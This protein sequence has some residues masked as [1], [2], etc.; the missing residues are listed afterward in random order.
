[1]FELL[2]VNPLGP[3]HAMVYGPVPP[4]KLDV[5]EPSL[6]PWQLMFCPKARI[7]G[8]TETERDPGAV[9]FQ[10][11]ALVHA[12]S[13]TTTE[14]VPASKLVMSC[15][16]AVNPFGPVQEYEYGAIPPFSVRFIAP[17]VLPLHNGSV[18]VEVS[19][20]WLTFTRR[21]MV[22]VQLPSDTRTE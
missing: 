9:T 13:V 16:K 2:D 18:I 17:F 12:A 3:L 4:L 1:M 20:R 6:P 22:R 10:L 5:I 19:A 21:L 14:Y 8:E 11:C 7:L 15:E